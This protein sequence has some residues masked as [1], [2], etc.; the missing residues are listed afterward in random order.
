MIATTHKKA[1]TFKKSLPSFLII[2][3][4]KA[5]CKAMAAAKP[6]KRN[7]F[8]P[9]IPIKNEIPMATQIIPLVIVC[10]RV[11][12]RNRS[13]PVSRPT[14][15]ALVDNGLIRKRVFSSAAKPKAAVI[16]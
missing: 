10:R 9:R 4:L 14:V 2:K 16:R 11:E 15:E 3:K 1:K 7:T 12:P 5:L 8:L 6:A 13:C